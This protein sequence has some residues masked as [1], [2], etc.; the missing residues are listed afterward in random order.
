MGSYLD[1]ARLSDYAPKSKD[2]YKAL[3]ANQAEENLYALLNEVLSRVRVATELDLFKLA[4]SPL[5]GTIQ[6]TCASYA[7]E[8]ERARITCV[9]A[10]EDSLSP[11][12]A[13]A[14]CLRK[15]AGIEDSQGLN[16]A[17][18]EELAQA[19]ALLIKAFLTSEQ[20][21]LGLAGLAAFQSKYNKERHQRDGH[22]AVSRLSWAP[23]RPVLRV[24]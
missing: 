3:G 18:I 5:L 21:R 20:K 24:G 19:L 7:E 12:R 14:R 22:N 8:L 2:E 23:S 13:I 11:L 17:E 4:D 9:P 1:V 16:G 15:S 6:T 10:G